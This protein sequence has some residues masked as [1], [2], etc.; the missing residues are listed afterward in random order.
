MRSYVVFFII[1]LIWITSLSGFLFGRWVPL[2]V[3]TRVGAEV[4]YWFYFFYCDILLKFYWYFI[5][6]QPS[7]HILLHWRRYLS[8]ALSNK[9]FWF[10]FSVSLSNSS[11]SLSF[12][13]T[14]SLSLLLCLSLSPYL[15]FSC[16]L[17][18]SISLSPLYMD[19]SQANYFWLV[20]W[21][22]YIFIGSGIGLMDG[23]TDRTQSKGV[24][25]K[26]NSTSTYYTWIAMTN[27]CD[28]QSD[29]LIPQ[30]SIRIDTFS[31]ECVMLFN[32]YLLLLFQLFPLLFYFLFLWR[33]ARVFAEMAILTMSL[34]MFPMARNSVWETVFG[35]PHDRYNMCSNIDVE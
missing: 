16:S 25:D 4:F 8:Y 26:Q 29:E 6:S 3:S 19:I 27:D 21:W 20:L 30:G 7:L 13:R 2:S 11:L 31:Y 23:R 34:L 10:S 9:T 1:E 12:S 18:L 17:L 33:Y 22:H 35:V 32:I 14:L 15:S 24:K 28:T 5:F